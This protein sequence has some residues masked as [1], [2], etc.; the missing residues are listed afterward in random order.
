VDVPFW[1]GAAGRWV[2]SVDGVDWVVM[3]VVRMGTEYWVSRMQVRKWWN[4]RVS[5]VV[6]V[7]G[8]AWREGYDWWDD[9]RDVDGEADGQVP[10]VGEADR[11]QW[12]VVEEEVFFCEGTA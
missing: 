2:A 6:T 10:R 11:R 4:G 9:G 8:M 12:Q 5:P 3:G 7:Q 1:L